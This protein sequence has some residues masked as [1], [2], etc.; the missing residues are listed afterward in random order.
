VRG[1]LKA[2][3]LITE[4]TG[5][6]FRRTQSHYRSSEV[7]GSDGTR[8]APRLVELVVLSPSGLVGQTLQGSRFAEMYD[9]VVLALRRRGGG[10]GPISTTP[11]QAGDVLVVEGNE[12]A[13]LALSQ[14][15]GFLMVGTPD[16]PE[17]RSG[18]LALTLATLVGVIAVVSFGLA[19]FVTAAVSGCAVLMLSGSLPP[20]E[21]YRAIDLSLVFTLSGSLALGVALEKTGIT[22]S[23]AQGLSVLTHPYVALV[24]FF[25]ISVAVSEM[26]SN[27][28][29]VALL[30]PLA[31]STAAHAGIN[32]MALLAAVTFGASAAFAMPVGYQTSL[33]IYGPGGYRFMDFVRMGVVLDLL[34]AGTALYLIPRYWP[35]VAP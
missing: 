28:G 16:R 15:R 18:Q 7:E 3:L 27:S 19:S 29:T 9:T 12:E 2:L 31:I 20:R 35:L 22:A 21:A 14:R 23:V 33:M 24:G 17:E 4:G 11:L 25:L 8:S 10:A 6:R 32:P 26:M 30:G 5:I 34:V 1:G 13:L